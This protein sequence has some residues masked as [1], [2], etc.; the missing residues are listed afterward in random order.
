MFKENLYK[1]LNSINEPN[2]LLEVAVM[3]FWN[4]GCL[5]LVEFVD[6]NIIDVR[7]MYFYI[8]NN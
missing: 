8:V 1:Y 6:Q 5:Y 4:F 3:A 7:F 2:N